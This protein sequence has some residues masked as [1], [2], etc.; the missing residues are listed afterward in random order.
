MLRD[1]V[2]GDRLTIGGI[3][4]AIVATGNGTGPGG[5]TNATTI[6]L[7]GIA[8]LAQY[9]AAL[10][11]ITFSN[12]TNDNP[13]NADRH[14]DV[15]V[16][17]GFKDNAVATTTVH[18]T[19]V[20]DPSVIGADSVLTNVGGNTSNGPTFVIPDWALLRNDSDVDTTLSVASVT[21]VGNT[22]HHHHWQRQRL[23]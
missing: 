14:I 2:A 5:L 22:R 19:P 6:T 12:P 16:N 7:A 11:A 15:T 17:D 1:P 21:N 10:A 20:E 23:Y 8:T 18:V 4:A 3:A 13:T 9:Q